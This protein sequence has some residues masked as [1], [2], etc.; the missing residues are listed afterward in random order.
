[1]ADRSRPAQSSLARARAEA[2]FAGLQRRSHEGAADRGAFLK[3]WRPGLRSADADWFFDRDDAVA[4]ARDL[5]RNEGIAAAAL[6]RRINSSVGFRWDFS[7]K[8]SARALGITPEAARELGAEIESAWEQYAYGVLFQADAERSAT[9]GQLLR[10]GAAH[11]FQDGE[12]FA[13]VEWAGDEGTRF[14]TRLRIVDPDRVTNPDGLADSAT[15]RRG[16]EK[17]AAGVPVAYHIREFHPSDVG[18]MGNMRWNRW[19]RYSTGYGRP[20]VL[21]AYDKLRAGQSRGVSRLVSVLKS[22][23]SL[24]RFT[25]ATLEAATINA[26]FAAFVKSTAGPSA[27]SEWFS[28]DDL[29]D[30]A[31]ER[32]DHYKDQPIELDGVQLLNLAP[33]DEVEML[34]SERQTGGFEAFSRTI[35]RFIAAALGVTYEELTMDFSST[36]YSSARAAMLIAW[37][38]TLALRGLIEAQIAWPFLFAWMDEAFDNG[39][40][41]VPAGAPAFRDAPD[42]YLEG[43]WRGPARGYIDETKEIAAA[44]D[45]IAARLS[46]QEDEAAQQGKDWRV[47]NEQLAAEAA[48]ADRL[49]LPPV[50]APNGQAPPPDDK[51]RDERPAAKAA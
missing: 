18:A 21:H 29:G 26:L 46:T 1:M 7:A 27:V 30:W 32:E 36:N 22:F 39:T 44:R 2:A 28:A 14:K 23:R 37:N 49:G 31:G 41:T 40:L 51:S 13:L 48:D 35:L 20:Q 4:R 15:L 9:F 3:N 6:N 34:T 38:E 19:P 11:I 33:D 43:A 16:V 45:R 8:P 12:A 24:S 50:V 47:V 25:E 17:T 42:A 5:G 10:M